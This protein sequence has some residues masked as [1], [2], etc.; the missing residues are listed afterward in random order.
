MSLVEVRKCPNYE[1]GEIVDVTALPNEHFKFDYWSGDTEYLVGAN[2]SA[3][4]QIIMPPDSNVSLLPVFKPLLY[5]VVVESDFNGSVDVNVSYL[6]SLIENFQ[7]EKN[8][9]TT[10]EYNATSDLVLFATP[11]DPSIYS[12]DK[13]QITRNEE[14]TYNV[15]ANI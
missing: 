5:N 8:S 1:Y 11:D 6:A 7:V 12:F 2:E 10:K 15:N 14:T 9:S 13:W 4:N 3:T